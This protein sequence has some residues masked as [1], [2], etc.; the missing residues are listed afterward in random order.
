M[1]QFQKTIG[2]LILGKQGF[3]DLLYK[4]SFI[5]EDNIDRQPG[6][7]LYNTQMPDLA[8]LWGQYTDSN[9]AVL[10]HEIG[11][12]FCPIDIIASAVADGLPVLKKKSDNTI[13]EDNKYINALLAFPFPLQNWR[14][15][16]YEKEAYELVTGK[17]FVYANVL[18]GLNVNYRTISTLVNLPADVVYIQTDPFI[19]VLS[20][21]KVEDMIKAFVVP[22]GNVDRQLITPNKVLYTKHCSLYAYDMNI[23]GRSPLLSAQKAVTVLC[24][25][26]TALN[27][28]FTKGGPRGAVVSSATDQGGHVALTPT[29]KKDLIKDLDSDYG[30]GS[31]KSPY[32]VTAQP[33]SWVKMGADIRDLM[34]ME[35]IEEATELIFSVYK[36]P[37]ELGPNKKGATFENQNNARKRVY[38]TIAIPRA[39]SLYASLTS[40]LKLD[41]V[42]LYLDVDFSHIHVLQENL[43]EKSAVDWRN[44]ETARVRFANGIITLNDWRKSCGLEV[45]INVFYDKLLYEMTPAELAQVEAIMKITGGS[46]AKASGEGGNAPAGNEADSAGN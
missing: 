41:E 43:K 46:S 35:T 23:R 29:E 3:E 39:K 28:I 6:L 36:V 27:V 31:K 9:L 22:N 32:A 26:Y 24:A 16:V 45:V 38:E 1:N 34:P 42:G 40:W 37:M 4:K 21:T 20:A 18:G 14:E 5:T 33:V 11:E 25:V 13:V 10:F 15:F 30:F 8:A 7:N 44:N 12:I 17:S 19:K 2:K